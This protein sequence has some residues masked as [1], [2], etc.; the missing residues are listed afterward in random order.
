MIRRIVRIVRLAPA[1]R[2][3]S[4][5]TF[6]RSRQALLIGSDL[7]G[8]R[9]TGKVVQNNGVRYSTASRRSGI[10]NCFFQKGETDVYPAA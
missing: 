2:I 8:R 10:G 4:P 7:A 9:R 3:V 6:G 5:A 1:A